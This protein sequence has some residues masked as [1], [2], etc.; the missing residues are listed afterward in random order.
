MTDAAARLRLDFV[1]APM[2][3]ELERQGAAIQQ[4]VADAIADGVLVG[5]EPAAARI[6]AQAE[7]EPFR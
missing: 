3:A 2:L 5:P 1:S 6:L 7:K 4:A